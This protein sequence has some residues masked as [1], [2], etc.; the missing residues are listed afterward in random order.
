MKTKTNT[1]CTI[2]ITVKLTTLMLI[3]FLGISTG[4]AQSLYL[5]EFS[6]SGLGVKGSGWNL[7]YGSATWT[8]GDDGAVLQLLATFVNQM[9]PG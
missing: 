8:V 7:N 2:D 5:E 9:E 1:S 4:F 3:G 6:T